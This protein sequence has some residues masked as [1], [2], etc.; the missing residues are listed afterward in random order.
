MGKVISIGKQDFASLRENDYFFVDKTNFIK[1]CLC[2]TGKNSTVKDVYSAY[3]DWCA[4]NGFGTES[5]ANFVSELKTKG[6]Y[7]ST[8][9]VK[10]KTVHNAV[11]GYEIDAEFATDGVE[12]TP[13]DS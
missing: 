4:D 1:E 8:A 7:A 3:S 13:F 6:L 11:K 9:T 2:R 12:S 5:K 10:G